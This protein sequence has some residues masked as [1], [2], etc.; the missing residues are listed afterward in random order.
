M[1]MYTVEVRHNFETAH[2]LATEDAPKKCQSIHGHSW[3]VTLVVCGPEID[4]S[5]MLIEFG[6][7]KK[8]WRSW[9]DT[10]ID[11]AL[12]LRAGDPMIEAVRGAYADSRIFVTDENPTTEVMARLLYERAEII[13]R[14]L[15]VEGVR[16]D[17][18]VL[19]ET[20]VNAAT[21][22]RD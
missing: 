1:S 2:R 6:A 8:A 13:V 3:W 15:G 22:S 19:N 14:E 21:Y 18:I 4:A 20:R 16:V 17:R 9:L 11:H 7:L 10:Y 5:G 12:V